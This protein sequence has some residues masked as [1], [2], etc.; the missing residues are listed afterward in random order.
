MPEPG[1]RSRLGWDVVVLLVVLAAAVA[2]RLVLAVRIDFP[3]NDGGLFVPYIE[4]TGRAFPGLPATVQ[5]NALELPN[6]YPPLGFWLGGLL[7]K[8]GVG[9]VETMHVL[10]PLLNAAWLVLL[11]LLLLRDRHSPLFAAAAVALVAIAFRS[12]EWL[13]MGGGLT[14]GLGAVFLILTLLAAGGTRGREVSPLPLRWAAVAGL[15]VGAALLSHLE[16]GILAAASLVVQRAL[17]S[18][19][20]KDFL[21]STSLAGGTAVAVVAPWVM[22]VLFH[23]GVEPFLAASGT[24]AWD[25]PVTVARLEDYTRTQ[26]PNVLLF[27]GGAVLLVRRH[28]FWPVFVLLCVVLTP[29]HSLTPLVLPASYLTASGLEAAVLAV[30]RAATQWRELPEV[31][32]VAALALVAAAGSVVAVDRTRV[33]NPTFQ[34]LSGQ[35]REAMAWVRQEQ[36]GSSFAVVTDPVWYYDASAEWFPAL[37]AA[38][39]ST[40][41]QGT[42]W[43]PGNAFREREAEVMA[44]K[45]SATCEELVQRVLDLAPVEYVWTQTRQAC[46]EGPAFS[47]V[48]TN[49]DVSI[50]E[51]G[52][53]PTVG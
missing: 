6:A 51:V 53:A 18:R 25:L 43:L 4:A 39:S 12:Y 10:P 8:L 23:H 46:F 7:T 13:V 37:T 26:W 19:S 29:R 49:A 3:I 45:A 24:S 35:V 9:A 16:W 40:T 30:R 36:A 5:Y 28:L 52:T 33:V 27:V 1:R 38:T 41:V 47:T 32:A 11:A 50:F 34:P 22:F 20:I 31:A 42:E 44:M 48:F 14:R 21:A 17:V 15:A 2:H